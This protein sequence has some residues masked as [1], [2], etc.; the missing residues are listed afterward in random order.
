[1]RDYMNWA[2]LALVIACLGWAYD[3]RLIRS[4]MLSLKTREFTRTSV[5]SGMRMHEIVAGSICLRSADRLLD[6]AQ[7]H[8]LVDRP[9]V[10]LSVLG[11]TDI[12]TPFGTP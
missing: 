8:Q 12:N 1:M 5:F 9:R 7:Q 11:F 10:T 4:L 6:H 3:A 2:L